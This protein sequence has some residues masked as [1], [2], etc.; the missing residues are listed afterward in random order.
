[1]GL[2]KLIED[3]LRKGEERAQEIIRQ[4][5]RE[6]D[7]PV[8]SADAELKTNSESAHKRAEAQITQLEQHEL[9][10]AELESRKMLLSAQREVLEDLRERILAELAVYPEDKKQML[11]A[12]LFSKA[13][14]ILG[15]CYVYSNKADNALLKRSPRVASGGI[16]DCLGGLVFE[17]KDRT[18]RL[19][20]KF[21]TM[22]EEIWGKK[23]N[24]I[25][26][27]LFG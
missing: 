15:D 23:M 11:Y 9:S 4:G 25:Y 19:D 10:S 27:Q 14:E 17:T 18:V 5:E 12:K 7:E 1:M 16:I 3:I 22:L 6:R 13:E 8:R 24:E 26:T 20:Y 2:E 21:E